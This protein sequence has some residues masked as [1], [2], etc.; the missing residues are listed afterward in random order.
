MNKAKFSIQKRVDETVLYNVY[1]IGSLEAGDILYNKNINGTSEILN[2]FSQLDKYYLD[3]ILDFLEPDVEYDYELLCNKNY[4]LTVKIPN[5]Y[6]NVGITK[7]NHLVADTNDS[8]NWDTIKFPLPEG[9]WSVY[10]E[11]GDIV[12]LIKV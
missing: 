9:K 11:Q 12:V 10:S 5:G 3:Y 7:T 8:S 4:I 6:M 2:T 1:G